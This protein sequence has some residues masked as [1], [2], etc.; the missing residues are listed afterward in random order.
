MA[1]ATSIRIA[2]LCTVLALG[3]AGSA[4]AQKNSS[5]IQVTGDGSLVWVVNPDSDSVTK[6][7]AA[8]NSF[9][10]EF[11]V[12]D[13]PRTLALD[14]T[15][16]WL[17]VTNH[18]SLDLTPKPSPDTVMRLDQTSGSVQE[19]HQ[20]PFGCAPFGV[21]VRET[22]GG[23][24]VYVSCQSM[25]QV[26]V[27]DQD[28]GATPIATISLDWPDPRNMVL[29][30]DGSRL[31]VAHFLTRE[32]SSSAHVSE[33]DTT[34]TPPQVVRVL[35]I[36]VDTTTCETVN[37]G[38]GV[39]NQLMGINLTP[40]GAP[41]SVANQLWVGGIIENDFNKGLFSRDKR[42]GGVPSPSFCQGG[43]NDGE[44]CQGD[45]DCSGGI[46]EATP[47]AKSRSLF[48]AA[49]EDLTRMAIYKIDLGTG[50]VV[51]KIDIDAG[52]NATDIVFSQDGSTAYTVDQYLHSLHI[53]NTARGQ[54]TDPGSVFAPV[55]AKGPGG[56]DPSEF[57]TGDPFDTVPEDPFILTPQVQIVP[58]KEDPL[59]VNA[60]VAN[61]GNDYLV[62]TAQ[63]RAVP[64]G[65]GTHPH[66]VALDPNGAK[67]YVANFFSRNLTVV[68]VDGFFCPPPGNEACQ[69]RLDCE[70]CVPRV[71]A[72]VPTIQAG[73]DPL[74]P[75]ILDG[76]IL[77]HTGAREATAGPGA[78]SPVAV[79]RFNFD[80]P[81]VIE[82]VGLVTSTSNFGSGIAC[83][84]CHP[85]G[86]MDGRVWDLSGLGVTTRSVM[87]LRGR[88]SFKPGVCT[89]PAATTCTTDSE[90][91]NN[92]VGTCSNDPNQICE[93]DIQCGSCEVGSP[94]AGEFC[95]ADAD[96]GE[97]FT[98]ETTSCTAAKCRP[99]SIDDIPR[100]VINTDD[101]FNPM[102]TIHWNGD[103]DEVE[104]FEG[105]FKVLMGASD[106][107]GNE[108]LPDV[109]L[110]ALVR[111]GTVARPQATAAA[112]ADT[113][114]GL[115]P[116]LDHMADYV[117]TLTSFVRNPN[118]GPG[119]PS[120]DAQ[121]GR[122]IFNSA[123]TG[124][125]ECH[126]GPSPS[127]QQ[128][129]DK[130]PL[131]SH[132]LGIPGGAASNNP[133]LRHNV[134]TF[135]EFDLADPGVVAEELGQ[136]HNSV[137]PIPGPRDPLIDF[138]TPTLIDVWNGAPYNHDG[139]AAT[140]FQGV[141]PCN[142]GTDEC[143]GSD[144]GKNINDQHG[145]TSRLTPQQ[146]LLLVE[147][148]KA[149]HGP[150][151]SGSGTAPA[152]P[153]K[154]L[155][156]VKVKFGPAESAD[157]SFDLK[158][159]LV[160]PPASTLDLVDQVLP[161]GKTVRVLNEPVT[162]TLTD[163]DAELVERTL[164]AGSLVANPK[165]TRLS[166]KDKTGT[167][168]Q[169]IRKVKLKQSKT[170]PREYVIQ[171]KAKDIDLA[172]LD[173]NHISVSVEIGDDAFVKT[174]TFKANSKRSTI[175]VKEK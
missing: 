57:C 89:A 48:K 129:T 147:F 93:L 99:V 9:V 8:T 79:P 63:M 6:I 157:D 172:T 144:A 14:D 59:F 154:R 18:G 174:R 114:R 61:T 51:G 103:Q 42:F 46:C 67:L 148:L 82:P 1:L 136:F 170:D 135:N 54:G 145:A 109:C 21:V 66:G 161:N 155:N 96:C 56:A 115:S 168:A 158:A 160:L 81:N 39:L 40:A 125:A 31:Y 159:T 64:D 77:F 5:P 166:F 62:T 146:L 24:E 119:G 83:A 36:S 133:F 25:Q 165:G 138:V 130:A 87:D 92:G 128:F 76:K 43:K 88:A 34:L 44:P 141:F 132:P 122:E 41:A 12:G 152:T 69:S 20:L 7:D 117:Y 78:G 102:G 86:G 4:Y 70:G 110:G 19:T 104:D 60:S 49:W 140:L 126:N 97:L 30:A 134:G 91:L 15:N 50:G 123:I 11:P 137:I 142:S 100:N 107:D 3:L 164:P 118:L 131:A 10:A 74:P 101:F 150:I 17:Y 33:I 111:A 143:G 112:L 72:V 13:Q 75:Q 35:E 27:L 68:K 37:S 58:F 65:V 127:N 162:I 171:V 73:T 116:R 121:A 32:P 29:S 85:E 106:C 98:C 167:I 94:S 105:A 80:D 22:G 173:K 151:G 16:G 120:A 47:T 156:K 139:G 149:P 95:I 45:A 153:F 124:C 163:V 55:S 113:N 26:I 71:L 84:S 52:N 108:H 175:Q 169:G 38:R 2:V 23:N 53:F 90:C 28:L